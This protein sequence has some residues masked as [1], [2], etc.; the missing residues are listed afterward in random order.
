MTTVSIEHIEVDKSGT[1]RI[2]GT[3]SRVINVVLDKRNGMTPDEIH[4]QYP[5]L[6]LAQIYAALAYYY[7]HQSE[8]DSQIERELR[9][10]EALRGNN[11][12]SP[13]RQELEA[14]LK[15]RPDREE[16]NA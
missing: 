6:S 2:A 7:D 11:D 12:Q 16:E 1:A 3:R 15:A 13:R 9:D 5:H 10:L 14:R 4:A 8:L